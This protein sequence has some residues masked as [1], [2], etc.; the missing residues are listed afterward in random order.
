[1]N[2]RMMDKVE[3]VTAENFSRQQ[4]LDKKKADNL[5]S[6]GQAAVYGRIRVHIGVHGRTRAHKEVH[7]RTQAHKGVHAILLPR[8][9]GLPCHPHHSPPP[10]SAL[11]PSPPSPSP[12]HHRHSHHRHPSRPSGRRA[13]SGWSKRT[14]SGATE[15][16]SSRSRPSRTTTRPTAR[17]RTTS[18]PPSNTTTPA[19][20]PRRAEAWRAVVGGA[21]GGAWFGLDGKH[22]T[23]GAAGA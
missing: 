2:S 17:S 23:S 21:K 6:C 15:S 3:E 16:T 11:P 22:C 20:R 8:C 18:S 7:R 10:W 9:L 4:F 13:R 19:P 5:V 1:M 14:R 12:L